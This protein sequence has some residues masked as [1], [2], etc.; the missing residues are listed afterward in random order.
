[1]EENFNKAQYQ[2]LCFTQATYHN[3]RHYDTKGLSNGYITITLK[4]PMTIFYNSLQYA[5]RLWSRNFN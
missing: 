4:F 1:L 2:I 5:Y 3:T